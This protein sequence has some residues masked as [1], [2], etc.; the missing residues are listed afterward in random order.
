[1][2]KRHV[3]LGECRRS[4]DTRVHRKQQEC[5]FFSG[6]VWWGRWLLL[7][8]AGRAPVHVED[9]ALR[10]RADGNEVRRGLLCGRGEVDAWYVCTM[11]CG[12]K[13]PKRVKGAFW[14]A[15][16][17]KRYRKAKKA[18][19]AKVIQKR[20]FSCSIRQRRGGKEA[21]PAKNSAWRG[22]RKKELF[23]VQN[24]HTIFCFTAHLSNYPWK[25]AVKEHHDELGVAV[26]QKN[27]FNKN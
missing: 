4:E 12:Y 25:T 2:P 19:T 7:L 8:E 20:E 5:C 13:R 24:P 26:K 27:I 22:C 16:K 14:V 17:R 11:L 6:K 23:F 21:N 10:L 3:T 9:D 1:M 15:N 18:K